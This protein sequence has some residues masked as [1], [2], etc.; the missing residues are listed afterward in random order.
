MDAVQQFRAQIVYDKKSHTCYRCGIS[1][2]FCATKEDVEQ[3]CQ[4]PFVVA[5]VLLGII[6]FPNRTE[7]DRERMLEVLHGLGYGGEL[8]DSRGFTR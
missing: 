4:W 1:Q 3:W 8:G 2:N 7:E 6:E 5:P